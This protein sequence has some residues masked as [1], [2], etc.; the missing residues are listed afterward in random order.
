MISDSIQ[1]NIPR[2]T[3]YNTDSEV[4][5]V[6]ELSGVTGCRVTLRFASTPKPGLE[7][8]IAGMLIEAFMRRNE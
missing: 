3:C 7:A 8:Q 5:S 2:S 1:N 4:T 6:M